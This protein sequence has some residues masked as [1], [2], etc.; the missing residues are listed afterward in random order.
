[1][2]E[3]APIIAP[4]DL[5]TQLF[6][7][8]VAFGGAELPNIALHGCKHFKVGRGIIYLIKGYAVA[9]GYRFHIAIGHANGCIGIYI[10]GRDSAVIYVL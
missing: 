6:I 7:D 9:L 1:M 4:A 2:A 5:Y 3:Y 8:L 10:T